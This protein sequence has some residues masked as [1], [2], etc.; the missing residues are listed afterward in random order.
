[1]KGPEKVG[2]RRVFLSLGADSRQDYV[3]AYVL[4]T[5]QRRDEP[6]KRNDYFTKIGIFSYKIRSQTDGILLRAGYQ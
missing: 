4:F 6:H 3:T 5:A 1:M 2:R